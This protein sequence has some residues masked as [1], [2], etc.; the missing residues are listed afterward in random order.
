M[1]EGASASMSAAGSVTGAS[2]SVVPAGMLQV[3]E[4]QMME[5]INVPVQQMVGTVTPSVQGVIT[6]PVPMMPMGMMIR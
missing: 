2:V 5:T 6:P 4:Q 1:M 3:G